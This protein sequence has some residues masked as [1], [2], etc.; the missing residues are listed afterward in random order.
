MPELVEDCPRCSTQH[1]TFDLLG[2]NLTEKKRGGWQEIYECFG[3]CRA[4]GKST[5]FT[6]AQRSGNSFTAGGGVMKISGVV[7]RNVHV[8]NFVSIKDL[9]SATCPDDLPPQIEALFK[10]GA[11]CL[12]VQCPNAA[13][14]MFRLC[15]DVATLGLLPA[16][17]SEEPNAKTR[18]DLGLR[19]P[20]LFQTER[21]HE[22]LRDLS[23]CVREDG[24]DAAHRGNLTQTDAEDLL[25][26]TAALLDRMYSEPARLVKAQARRDARRGPPG[27]A[28]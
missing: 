3:V 14:M 21:L 11:T 18:R 15:I 4:C 9:S 19:L 28:T 1:V 26:F 6:L 2:Q 12:A 8:V 25:D 23:T 27:A 17:D 16:Q 13:G 5:V 24:N 22:S 10:E 20:W 7:N